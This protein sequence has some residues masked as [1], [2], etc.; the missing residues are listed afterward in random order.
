MGDSFS[1]WP[2]EFWNDLSEE[3][4]D[5]L[6]QLGYTE[7]TWAPPAAQAHEEAAE[8]KEAQT[9]AALK[10]QSRVR[11]KQAKKVVEEKRRKKAAGA[12]VGIGGVSSSEA[13]ANNGPAVVGSMNDDDEEEESYE[14]IEDD[15]EDEEDDVADDDEEEGSASADKQ[16]SNTK[17]GKEVDPEDTDECIRAAAPERATPE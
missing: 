7:E 1:G 13:K 12:A 4:R 3:N 9:K 14:D 17:S 15:F 2:T 11:G 16:G 5:V 10:I 8:E 6:V